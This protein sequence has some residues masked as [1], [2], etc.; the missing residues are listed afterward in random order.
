MFHQKHLWVDFVGHVARLAIDTLHLRLYLL[1]QRLYLLGCQ[2]V[3]ILD[4]L[5]LEPV[6][7]QDSVA[8]LCD[9][10]FRQFELANLL[11]ITVVRINIQ[12]IL[13]Y[14]VQQVSKVG[15]ELLR[16]LILL[17][18]SLLHNVANGSQ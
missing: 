14:L 1:Y 11:F 7:L 4:C 18:F 13:P 16:R 10:I 17:L 3:F 5:L 2:V 12:L 15:W 8:L 6:E 9:N